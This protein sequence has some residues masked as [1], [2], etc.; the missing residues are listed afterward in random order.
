MAKKG[1][2]AKTEPG[3]VVAKT[4]SGRVVENIRDATPPPVY[5]NNVTLLMSRWDFK[6]VFG[7]ILDMTDDR[8]RVNERVTVVMSPQHAAAFSDVLSKHVG[9]YEERFGPIP[10][11][12]RQGPN[13]TGR[14]REGAKG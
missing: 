11:Q 7:D 6:F 12:A 9:G 14:S 1:R 2:A 5:A 8:L 3:R 4:E 13:G 10:R